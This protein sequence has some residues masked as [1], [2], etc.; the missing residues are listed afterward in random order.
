[1]PGAGSGEGVLESYVSTC[2]IEHLR[3]PRDVKDRL[4]TVGAQLSA[5]LGD[6]LV[7]AYLYGSL[8]RGCFH[9]AASDVDA[10]VVTRSTCEEAVIA[11]IR[12]HAEETNLSVDATFVAFAQANVDRT[13][14][15]VDFTLKPIGGARTVRPSGGLPDFLLQR[16]DAYECDAPLVGSAAREMLRPV[17]W[18]ALSECLDAMLPQML[19]RFKNPALMLCRWAFAFANRRI[20]SKRS[21]KPGG[22]LSKK[23]ST[24]TRL[25]CRMIADPTSRCAPSKRT[26]SSTPAVLPSGSLLCRRRRGRRSS[27]EAPMRRSSAAANSSSPRTTVT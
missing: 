4:R 24:S 26:A 5:L 7:G 17:A 2:T 23:R 14:T 27:F 12:E 10:I 8:P 25:E 22:P 15:P 21:T 20:G 18:P 16:Q 9:P 6:D 3:C 1:V 19:P 11:R 13:P